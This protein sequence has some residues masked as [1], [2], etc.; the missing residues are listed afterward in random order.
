VTQ[1]SINFFQTKLLKWFKSNGRT[2]LPWFNQPPYKVWLSEIMLQQTQVATVLPYFHKFTETFPAITDLAHASEETICQLWAGLGYYHRARNLHRTACI[3]HEQ[4]Q[5]EFPKDLKKLQEL[6]GIGPSTAAAIAS[7]A[8]NLPHAIFDGNVKRVLARYFGIETEI[9]KKS[10]LKELE[11]LA[12]ACMPQTNCQSYTQA[13]MDMGATCCQPKNPQCQQCPLNT[14]CKAYLNK[15]TMLIPK[16]SPKKPKPMI[17]YHYVALYNANSSVLM[18]KRSPKGIWPHLWCFPALDVIK[19]NKGDIEIR[20]ELT[21]QSMDIQIHLKYS[22]TNNQEGIWISELN[23]QELG[24]PKPILVALPKV[25]LALK[26]PSHFGH[27]LDHQL[28][29]D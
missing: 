25:F 7:L 22:N 24:L 1:Q 26:S 14:N 18:I 6:P 13:I 9:D 28:Q 8:F 12:N 10:T 27:Q 17:T 20:H 2:H 3:I 4:Y 19:Q 15:K 23:F 5:D 11:Q 21:H 16:K 29:L